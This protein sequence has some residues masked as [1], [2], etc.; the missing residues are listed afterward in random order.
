MYTYIIRKERRRKRKVKEK[1]RKREM[2]T[3][4]MQNW[5]SYLMHE[6]N[7]KCDLRHSRVLFHYSTRQSI[8]CGLPHI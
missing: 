5:L 1:E 4:G 6:A 3:R 2:R 8:E 7:L